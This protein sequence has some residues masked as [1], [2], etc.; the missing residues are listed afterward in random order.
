MMQKRGIRR[1]TTANGSGLS[2]ALGSLAGPK[3]QRGVRRSNS[4]TSHSTFSRV[5]QGGG[6]NGSDSVMFHADDQTIHTR[7]SEYDYSVTG[8]G[9]GMDQSGNSHFSSNRRQ[10]AGAGAPG[11]E[12]QLGNMLDGNLKPVAANDLNDSFSLYTSDNTNALSE[13]ELLMK[14]IQEGAARAQEEDQD[15]VVNMEEYRKRRS[16]EKR[17][18]A[19]AALPHSSTSIAATPQE[20]ADHKNQGAPQQPARAPMSE[21]ERKMSRQQ[22]RRAMVEKKTAGRKEPSMSS[23]GTEESSLSDHNQEH[24]QHHHHHH[25]NMPETS[26]SPMPNKNVTKNRRTSRAAQQQQQNM[27]LSR[28]SGTS[29]H[30]GKFNASQPSLTTAAT[31]S[32]STGWDPEASLPTLAAQTL[33]AD[34]SSMKNNIRPARKERGR[35][36][37]TKNTVPHG[38]SGEETDDS[39]RASKDRLDDKRRARSLTRSI[40]KKVNRSL[41]RTMKRLTGRREQHDSDHEEETM[42]ASSRK[43]GHSH[44]NECTCPA[45]DVML[46]SCP[47]HGE[48]AAKILAKRKAKEEKKEQQRHKKDDNRS[49]KS[50]KSGRKFGLGGRSRKGDESTLGGESKM[51]SN[52]RYSRREGRSRSRAGGGGANSISQS[53]TDSSASYGRQASLEMNASMPC[54]SH[55]PHDGSTISRQGTYDGRL[56]QRRRAEI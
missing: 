48:K 5:K 56:L 4:F 19:L 41:S 46:T 2:G 28:G 36:P 43:H 27:D 35:P 30:S 8:M 23:G 13:E 10:G 44:K 42:G 37:V 17:D 3:P 9:L 55:Q 1:N 16:R 6:V 33:P 52:S 45:E 18:M 26:L 51:T 20:A 21:R 24:E 15:T 39:S 32:M 22:S 54:R 14:A 25:Q 47:R 7:F 31:H 38:T 11:Q 34:P 40:A 12:R 50:S 53:M 49:M 29:A